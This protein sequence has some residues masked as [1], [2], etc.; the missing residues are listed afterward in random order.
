MPLFKNWKPKTVAGKILKGAT[1]GIGAA[2]LVATGVGAVGGVVGGAGLLAGAAKGIGL[3]AKAGKAIVSAPVKATSKIAT[4]ATNLVT[5]TTKDQRIQIRDVKD[6]AKAEL[7]KLDFAKKLV[8][9]GDSL[10]SA[11]SK[12]GLSESQL[13]S[14]L[15]QTDSAGQIASGSGGSTS[16]IA[17]NQAAMFGGVG[18]WVKKNPLYAAGAALLL[19]VLAKNMKIIK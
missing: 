1:I 3:A 14:I 11:A 19:F 17:A 6:T 4:A 5:G 16:G 13:A 15:G 18:D 8:N 7:D 12:A 2:A 10:K 9:A